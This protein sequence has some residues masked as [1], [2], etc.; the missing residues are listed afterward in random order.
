MIFWF[1][2]Q[3]GSGKSTLANALETALRVRDYQVAKLEGEELRRQT[4]NT[5]F[6]DAGR[7]LNVRNGQRRAA[8]LAASGF[9]VLAAFVSPHRTL[10]EEFKASHEV[11]EIYVHTAKATTKDAFR[12]PCYEPP[13]ARYV[14][15]DTSA[16]TVEQCVETILAAFRRRES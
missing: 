4:G 3:P 12:V 7:M 13:L 16:Q 14:D 9:V 6:S 8:E 10:R 2:G 11:L 15:L 5:D 1:T